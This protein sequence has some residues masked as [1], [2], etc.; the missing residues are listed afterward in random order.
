[1]VA[2]VGK[3]LAGSNLGSNKVENPSSSIRDTKLTV[4]SPFIAEGFEF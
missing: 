4:I 3:N 2:L 1:M